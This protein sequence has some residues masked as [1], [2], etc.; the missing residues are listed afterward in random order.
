MACKAPIYWSNTQQFILKGEQISGSFLIKLTTV[1]SCIESNNFPI[2]IFNILWGLDYRTLEYQTH[3]NTE[4]L[5]VRISKGLVLERLVIAKA[6]E[7]YGT[8]QTIINQK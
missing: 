2:L 1:R 5:A 6:K 4:R 7:S 3:W 8:D